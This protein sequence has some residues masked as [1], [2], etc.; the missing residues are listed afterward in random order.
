MLSRKVGLQT[1]SLARISVGDVKKDCLLPLF[2]LRLRPQHI[3]N[4]LFL[5]DCWHSQLLVRSKRCTTSA[6][7][8]YRTRC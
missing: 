4:R 2:Y 6:A 3:A 7:L 8:L 5:R 1:T